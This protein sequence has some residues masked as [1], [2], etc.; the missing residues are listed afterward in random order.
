MNKEISLKKFMISLFLFL[1][2]LSIVLFFIFREFKPICYVNTNECKK[3]VCS[4]C[5]EENNQRFCQNCS[6]FNEDNNRIW[7]GECIFNK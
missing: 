3:A 2:F 6:L 5:K 7:T 1:I 4:K